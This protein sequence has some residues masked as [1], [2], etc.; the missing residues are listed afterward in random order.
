VEVEAAAVGVV[1]RDRLERLSADSGRERRIGDEG[2]NAD[3]EAD[4]EAEA[5]IG[6]FEPR[7]AADAGL[8]GDGD[9][10]TDDAAAAEV[11]AVV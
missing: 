7:K 4:A 6:L 8:D 3:A 9:G 5:E 1:D 10:E 2:P 11:G